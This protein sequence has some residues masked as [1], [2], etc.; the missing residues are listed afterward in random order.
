MWLESHRT[1]N[2]IWH[3]ANYL[4][5]PCRVD[6]WASEFVV[7]RLLADEMPPTPIAQDSK[8]PGRPCSTRKAGS[9][10]SH[11]WRTPRFT[12]TGS[13]MLSETEFAAL[14]FDDL[15][16]PGTTR[17]KVRVNAVKAPYSVRDYPQQAPAA[18]AHHAEW[19][20]GKGPW[21]GLA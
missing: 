5:V 12:C 16:A 10:T 20:E 3:E 6:V 18:T 2:L 14:A 11:R 15:P 9:A 7:G 1:H 13:T 4:I 8:Q 19:L 21:R 17:F